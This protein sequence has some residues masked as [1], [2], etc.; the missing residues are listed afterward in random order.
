MR[1]NDPIADTWCLLAGTAFQ[2]DQ[3]L[4]KNI[5]NESAFARTGNTRHTAEGVKGKSD[6]DIL[7]VVL[8]SAEYFQIGL[9]LPAVVRWENP[10][11][12]GQVSG[13]QRFR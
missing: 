9:R 5:L 8:S 13:G 11:F 1:T 7:E 12:P 3:I 6:F 2:P 4:V 10:F